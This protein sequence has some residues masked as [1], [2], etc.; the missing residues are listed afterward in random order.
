MP[1]T[2]EGIIVTAVFLSMF[3]IYLFIA[4]GFM[5]KSTLKEKLDEKTL[6]LL[7]IFFLQPFLNFW[8][9]MQ[10][11]IDTGLVYAPLLYLAIVLLLLPMIFLLGKQLFADMKQRS[12]F[13]VSG[14]VG[15]TANLGIPVGIV[16]FGEESIPYTTVI[17]IANVFFVYTVG[18][19]FYSRGNFSVRESL[20]NIIKLPVLWSALLAIVCNLAGITLHPSIDRVL[21]MGAYASIVM[22]LL[23][24]GIYLHS[25]QIRSITPRLL[26]GVHTVKFVLLPLVALAVLLPVDLDPMIKGILFLELLMPL[27]IANV[28][29]AS[30]YDCRPGDVTVL[31]LMS[32]VLF[33]GIVF[34]GIRVIQHFGWL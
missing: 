17:N 4:V 22:Q 31:I 8:G 16:I 2:T 3:A 6:V 19:Y 26:A 25:V 30:L 9:L 20:I 23:I 33:M 28:N 11:P 32:S 5:A 29:F 27:A 21:E 34:G 13:I 15:N 1:E 14:L 18:V 24:F 10:R 7:S 12:I